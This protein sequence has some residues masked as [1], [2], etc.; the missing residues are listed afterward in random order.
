MK[1]EEGINKNLFL[2]MTTETFI[3]TECRNYIFLK[4]KSILTKLL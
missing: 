1:I 3:S 4:D 2:F